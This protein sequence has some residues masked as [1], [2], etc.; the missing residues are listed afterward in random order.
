MKKA[1]LLTLI[2]IIGVII[3]GCYSDSTSPTEATVS[4]KDS[5]IF[6]YGR[7]CPHCKIVEEFLA[8]N[9]VR[10]KVKF[11]EAEVYHN[12]GNKEI[13]IEK[14]EACGVTDKTKMGVPMLWADGQCL[15]GQED[16]IKYFQDKIETGS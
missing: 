11:S 13:F 1:I 3:W 5:V 8:K 4:A 7:E 12:K 2:I 14:F 10:D 6:F 16:V 15:V 9:N